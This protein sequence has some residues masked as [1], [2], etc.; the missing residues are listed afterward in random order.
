VRAINDTEML[1]RP[2]VDYGRYNGKFC[3]I[4]IAQGRIPSDVWANGH[5]TPI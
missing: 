4:N 2:C 5:G 3:D 1:C